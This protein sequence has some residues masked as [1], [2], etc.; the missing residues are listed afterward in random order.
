MGF[1]DKKENVNNAIFIHLK[2]FITSLY[3]VPVWKDHHPS[4]SLVK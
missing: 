3:S 2:Y 1:V 4:N